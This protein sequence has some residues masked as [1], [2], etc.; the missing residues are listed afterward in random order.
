[1][2]DSVSMISIHSI[3]YLSHIPMP[4]I[5]KQL[6][7]VHNHVERCEQATN[8]TDQ[9][10][11]QVTCVSGRLQIYTIHDLVSFQTQ[12]PKNYFGKCS[13]NPFIPFWAFIGMMTGAFNS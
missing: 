12:M 9:S 11:H 10:S 3:V 1:M 6:T 4:L 7:F 13:E 8:S 5:Q 2:D